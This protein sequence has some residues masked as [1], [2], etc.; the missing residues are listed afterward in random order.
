MR[1]VVAG[2]TVATLA[3]SLTVA[4]AQTATTY[5][6]S[7]TTGRCSKASA[8]KIVAQLGLSDPFVPRPVG[9]VLCGS[10]TGPGSQTMVVSLWGEGNSGLVEW[11]VFRWAG[12][13]GSS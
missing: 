6:G 8:R 2:L 5:Q 3:V 9:R 11:T 4:T 7:A 1:R 13:P 10:F 12:A